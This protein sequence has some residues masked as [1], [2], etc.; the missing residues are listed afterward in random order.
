MMHWPVRR[1]FTA[2]S[3]LISSAVLA[4]SAAATGWKTSRITGSPYPPAPF[5]I[6]RAF[7]ALRFELPTCVVEI[8]G[9]E[10]LL[11]TERAGRVLTFAKRSDVAAADLAADLSARGINQLHHAAFH[12]DFAE[13]PLLFV[14]GTRGENHLVARYRVSGESPPKLI[15]ESEVVVIEWPAGGHSGGCVQFGT[16]G[17]LYISIGDGSGP[18][19]PDSKTTGQDV[20][21]LLGSILRID[22][23]RT[24]AGRNYAIPADNP[25]PDTPGVRP[26]VW[27]YG[28][29]NP[30]KFGI[31]PA[32]NN[33]FAADN[34]WETW[35]MVY[36]LRGGSNGG[37]PIMEGRAHLRTEVPRGPTPITP[38]AKDHPHS[39]ANSVIGGPVY[40]GEKLAELDGWFIYGDYIT[41]TIWGLGTEA[42]G[43]G[44]HAH[45]TLC[46]TDQR[47]VAF[48]QGSAGEVYV[49]DYDFTG[50]IYELL[51]ADALDTSEDFPRRLSETGLFASLDPLAPAAGVVPYDVVVPQWMDGAAMTRWVAVP[52]DEPTQLATEQHEAA[53]YPEGTVLAKLVRLESARGDPVNLETQVLH[54]ERGTW[55]PYSY[56][57]DDDGQDAYLVSAAGADRTVSAA[58]G[59]TG[60]EKFQ[61]TWHIGAENECRLCHNAGPGFVLG[62]EPHQ[63]NRREGDSSSQLARLAAQ[64]AIREVPTIAADDPRRLVDPHDESHTI[65]D[66][67]RSYLHANCSMC[68]HPGGNA[69]VSFFLRRDMPFDELRTDKGTG[70]GTFGL[71]D[72]RIIVPGDPYR[73]ILLYRMAKLG[74]GRMPYIGS[75]VVDPRGIVLIDEWIR[76]LGESAPSGNGSQPLN[77]APATTGDA[78][79]VVVRLHAGR[80]SLSDVHAAASQGAASKSSD[81]RGLFDTFLPESERSVR[82][83]AVIEPSAILDLTGDAARGKLIY[84]SDNARC[85][86]CHEADDATQPLGPTLAEINKAYPQR[87]ELLDQILRPSFKI[88]DKYATQVVTT[89]DGQVLTGVIAEQTGEEVVLRTAEPRDVR[90]PRERID[91]MTKSPLSLMPERLLSDMT[92]QEAADLLAFLIEEP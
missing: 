84:F 57:W 85:R 37:W 76:S 88:D 33:V 67:A 26:E 75:Q 73:S 52:G 1:F 15:S 43:D 8:P 49:V 12:P 78:L 71:D 34:G 56:V 29:R 20:S 66:R 24:D 68:H 9:A 91:D 2:I 44:E 72:A 61:R 13:S 59:E 5:R 39:E 38:P 11:V 81:I 41:G 55:R 32:T 48:A 46:D 17:Y 45:R 51:P 25:F 30:W 92:P 74:Y 58:G 27:A 23:N 69:I 77:S 22:V 42:G 50:A 62:F 90:I 54:Y 47:I 35:E 83:G 63:L 89:T 6:E 28:L 65:D 31:D 7:P 82:L 14:S 53:T 16:D 10:R 70:V 21:D 40:R 19:P 87:P 36:H 64:Q 86:N 3:L 18:N 60:G 4:P 80:D 79:A